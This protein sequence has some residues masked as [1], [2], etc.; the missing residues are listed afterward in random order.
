MVLIELINVKKRVGSEE[1]LKGIDLKVHKGEFLA[2]I[3]AS[4]SG[5]SSLLYIMGL[6]DFPTEGE[7]FF[8]GQ[9]VSSMDSQ[10]VSRI[11]NESIGFVFQF[12]YLLPEFTLLENVMIP[13]LKKGIQRPQA[14]E[15]A[16]E[17]LKSLGL[18]GKEKRKI[19]QVSGGEMQRT[20]IARALANNPEVIL[21][22]EPTGNLD[23]KNTA[24]VMQILQEINR[25][26]TTVVMVTHE[27]ELAKKANRILQMKDGLLV[28]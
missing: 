24:I 9:Q 7:V 15:R 13:M 18:G 23:S 22:D 21:A 17:L 4:G 26:G 1:I 28:L 8:K 2:I 20:A 25:S 5:K 16:R 10:M 14:E 12:H 11:R 3:G 6:L 27:L 19:Y